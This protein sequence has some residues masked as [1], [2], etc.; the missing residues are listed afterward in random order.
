M[1]TNMVRELKPG[2][3]VARMLDTIK[4]AKSMAKGSIYGKM[5]VSMM[6]AG[7]RIK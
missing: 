6:V 5:A 2:Q 1:T 4:K 3:M 7:F